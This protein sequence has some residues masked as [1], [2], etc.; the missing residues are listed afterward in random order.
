MTMRGKHNLERAIEIKKQNGGN[1]HFL[2]II[3]QQ[4][5]TTWGSST[6][7]PQ[8]TLREVLKF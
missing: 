2:E 4:S 6:T 7:W 5:E 8:M 1:Q 3:K